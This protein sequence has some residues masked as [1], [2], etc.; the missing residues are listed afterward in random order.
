MPWRRAAR[1]IRGPVG[2]R[3]TR[4]SKTGT[5]RW[6]AWPRS[7]SRATR[8]ES[9]SSITGGRRRSSRR[10]GA[11]IRSSS[12][13]CR[14]P[15]PPAAGCWCGRAPAARSTRSRATSSRVASRSPA[16]SKSPPCTSTSS[17]GTSGSGSAGSGSCAAPINSSTGANEG[18][19]S[20]DDFLA[21]LSS[22]KRKNLKRE[23]RIARENG[24]E[25]EWVTGADLREHHWDAFFEFYLDTG[26]RKWGRP[27]LTR[28]FFGLVGETLADRTLLVMCRR[29]GRY[30]AGALN[31]IRRRHPVRAQ[32]GVHRGFTPC[33]ISRR[34]TTRPSSSRSRTPRLRGGRRAGSAQDCPRLPAAAYPQRALDCAR[35]P[36]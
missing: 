16:G 12:G 14:S 21:R 32:L 17:R 27:Y 35:G 18:Y 5:G 26:S 9:T 34:A 10:G 7:T 24:V 30:V 28:R 31:F 8:R 4:C 25:V 3:T 23:R 11:T 36:S 1:S 6:S 13:R 22:R 2:C 19:A 33:C 15:R 20:F 29:A